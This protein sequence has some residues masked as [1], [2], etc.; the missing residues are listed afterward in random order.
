MSTHD[1]KIV[2]AFERPRYLT[3]MGNK[4]GTKV[5]SL[6]PSLTGLWP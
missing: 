4:T 1:F 3:S 6:P 5:F 2:T